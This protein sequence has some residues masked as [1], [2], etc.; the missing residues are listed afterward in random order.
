MQPRL[1]RSRSDSMLAGVCSGLG[2]YFIID[3]VIV[4]L[5]FV[6][7][8]LST[9]AGIPVYFLLW[10][11][12]P[13]APAAQSV[14]GAAAPA[15]GVRSAHPQTPAEPPGLA[16]PH[17]Q[18]ASTGQ[19]VV[20][21]PHAQSAAHGSGRMAHHAAHQRHQQPHMQQRFG[22]APPYHARSHHHHA[23]PFAEPPAA[24]AT[25]DQR[26][27]PPLPAT[28]PP[29]RPPN[30]RTLGYVLVAIGILVLLENIGITM[31][32]GFPLLL[33][34]AGVALLVHGWRRPS[35]SR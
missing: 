22:A 31:S 3:P 25:N 5:I 12:T 20:Q 26:T 19:T 30:W 21:Q 10:I 32:L 23:A 27:T 29:R 24:M 1:T 2:D 34:I 28:A 9:G 8:T 6:L 13:S 4:R 11:L 17:E 14:P 18:T 33:I 35:R 7:V 15:H 16:A